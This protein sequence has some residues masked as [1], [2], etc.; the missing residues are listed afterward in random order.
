[1]LLCIGIHT[2]GFNNNSSTDLAFTSSVE[3]A[4]LTSK[5]ASG[6][7]SPF[8]VYSASKPTPLRTL[9]LQVHYYDY[10]YCYCYYYTYY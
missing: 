10:T 8:T 9:S 6:S 1:M 5:R 4:A 3:T 2:D 7:V